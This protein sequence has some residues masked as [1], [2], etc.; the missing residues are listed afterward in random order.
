MEMRT[1]TKYVYSKTWL[2][3]LWSTRDSATIA[4]AAHSR[5]TEM[6]PPTK[7]V[8][9]KTWPLLLQ[10]TRDFATIASATHSRRTEM[11]PP[12][13]YVYTNT[14]PLLL[15]STRGSATIA[16]ATQSRGINSQ[17]QTRPGQPGKG[18]PPTLPNDKKF[19]F[20]I[21]TLSK[22]MRE[23]SG[24]DF[25]EFGSREQGSPGELGAPRSSWSQIE[26]E[27]FRTSRKN[28]EILRNIKKY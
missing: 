1:P 13:K 7:Y 19:R 22:S 28:H 2:L 26:L 14:W 6:R 23:K 8:C 18:P 15:Q 3:L 24:W 11:R 20:L 12:T 27:I 25:L 17:D 5:R 21:E 10:S 4:S 16:S 9:T